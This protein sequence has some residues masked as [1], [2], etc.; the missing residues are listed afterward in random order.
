MLRS[1]G[2]NHYLCLNLVHNIFW[3]LLLQ[4]IE[5]LCHKHTANAKIKERL[6]YCLL[7]LSD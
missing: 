3:F 7:K 2:N 4:L 1:S 5:K 6:L